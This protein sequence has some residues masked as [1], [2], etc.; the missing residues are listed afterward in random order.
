MKDS[1]KKAIKRIGAAAFLAGAKVHVKLR[2]PNLMAAYGYSQYV[3]EAAAI[4]EYAERVN[5]EFETQTTAGWD[6]EQK[7]GDVHA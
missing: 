7:K 6:F 1:I 4:D 2:T 5:H 3:A